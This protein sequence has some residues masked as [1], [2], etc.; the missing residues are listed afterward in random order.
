[1]E[2]NTKAIILKVLIHFLIISEI[3]S[4]EI[5]AAQKNES[6]LVKRLLTN[7]NKNIRPSNQV[8]VSVYLQLK[9]IISLVEKTQILTTTVF[10][11]QAWY[12]ERLTWNS[13]NGITYLQ[14]PLKSI[15]LPDTNIINSANSD[16]YIPINADFG[17][18]SVL[19]SGDV[20]FMS[21]MIALSTRCVLDVSTFPFDTQTCPIKLTSWSFKDSEIFYFPENSFIYLGDDYLNNTI[22]S[23]IQTDVQSVDFIGVDAQ[24]WIDDDTNNTLLEF[25]LTIQ[26][27]GLF[28]MMN[29]VFPC[30]LLN[31]VTLLT[32]FMPFSNGLGLGHFIN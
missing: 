8:N 32:F 5:S 11:V 7:Y 18:A 13:S 17:Y 31:I 6:T 25:T 30:F 15:W 4:G 21:P 20:Y 14:L 12:D 26:R 2:L 10:V 22:W 27:N 3:E 16:G 1:M 28:Y 19:Y 29:S 24:F 9:Q 23:L